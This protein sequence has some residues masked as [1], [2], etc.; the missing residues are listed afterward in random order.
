MLD[1]YQERIPVIIF[2]L[3]AS[4]V[5][6]NF[7]DDGLQFPDFVVHEKRSEKSVIVTAFPL[8]T[9]KYRHDAT[10]LHDLREPLDG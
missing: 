5:M 3:V 6:L 10:T 8:V 7:Y 9:N 1:W 2:H 4:A